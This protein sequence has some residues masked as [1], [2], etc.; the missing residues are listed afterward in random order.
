[1]ASFSQKA[2]AKDLN[3]SSGSC[4]GCN[5]AVECEKCENCVCNYIETNVKC[6]K[7]TDL[8]PCLEK[9]KMC[10]CMKTD[11]RSETKLDVPL[12]IK[13]TQLKLNSTQTQIVKS[14]ETGLKSE[15][16]MQ[17]EQELGFGLEHNHFS[18][19][20]RKQTINKVEMKTEY[21]GESIKKVKLLEC[22]ASSMEE[23]L[24]QSE[25]DDGN[26]DYEDDNGNNE[27]SNIKSDMCGSCSGCTTDCG[28]CWTC[29]E[30]EIVASKET[31]SKLICQ[32][33][34]CLRARV[35]EKAMFIEKENKR[36][37]RKRCGICPGCTL[38]ENCETCHNC[39]VGKKV[40]RNV[41]K[42][43]KCHML[44]RKS[45]CDTLKSKNR[46]HERTFGPE[47]KNET[48]KKS[49]GV[50]IKR[51][52]RCGECERCL[53]QE[54]GHCQACQMNEHFNQELLLIGK[55][56]CLT[57]S[58]TNPIELSGDVDIMTATAEQDDTSSGSICPV[59]IVKGLLYDFRCFFCKKL[60]RVGSANRSELMRHYST[61]HYADELRVEFANVENSQLCFLC[62][63][64]LPNSSIPSHFGQKH[65]QVLKYLP[66]EAAA[67]I[68]GKQLAIEEQSYPTEVV[69]SEEKNL[70]QIS[71]SLEIPSDIDQSSGD[72]SC[73]TKF[74]YDN[75]EEV[76]GNSKIMDGWII[77]NDAIKDSEVVPFVD[78]SSPSLE[79]SEIGGLCSICRKEFSQ[80]TKT[81]EHLHQDHNIVGSFE[82][83]DE[84]CQNFIESGYIRVVQDSHAPSSI[85]AA[86]HASC[87]AFENYLQAESQRHSLLNSGRETDEDAS[88]IIKMNSSNSESSQRNTFMSPWILKE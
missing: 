60:P 13:T 11:Y 65:G 22:D 78:V 24:T 74:V 67:L 26:E 57:N 56:S 29:M 15:Y 68:E 34:K 54:C 30:R 70:S 81:A 50:T 64:K 88:K 42:Q 77:K 35:S 59:K 38:T 14:D 36:S 41:C 27:L 55:V 46:G 25:T 75:S 10:N 69:S 18:K 73:E 61:H 12:N 86:D 82:D 53:S 44:K 32:N 19:L 28:S 33:K 37:K 16:V 72:H 20:K 7:N 63:V 3:N 85:S 87:M 39:L 1:M 51:T 6:S 71:D 52:K 4:E 40:S 47:Y 84:D 83:I 43:R 80:V 58:C 23:I 49:K 62:D 48:T 66:S 8:L 76:E 31:E 21:E 45:E 5:Q 9:I 2:S 17:S 79:F